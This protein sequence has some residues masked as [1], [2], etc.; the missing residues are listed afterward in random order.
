M[1]EFDFVTRFV[2][3]ASKDSGQHPQ[4]LGGVSGGELE[5][6]AGHDLHEARAGGHQ[7][8]ARGSISGLHH[9]HIYIFRY[10]LDYLNANRPIFDLPMFT[11]FSSA[12]P[13]K[14]S[15]GIYLISISDSLC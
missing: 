10:V 2:A 12:H 8:T 7:A 14:T 4:A 9:R 6:A 5:A 3:L 11:I 13:P 15:T 1:S